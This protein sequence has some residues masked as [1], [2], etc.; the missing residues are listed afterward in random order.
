M[1]IVLCSLLVVIQPENRIAE[2]E[3]FLIPGTGTLGGSIIPCRVWLIKQQAT[4]YV[5]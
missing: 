2:R 3:R 4:I 1:A 5:R